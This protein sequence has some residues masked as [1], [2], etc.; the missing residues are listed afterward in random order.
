MQQA[1]RVSDFTAFVYLGRL[2]EYG[3]TERL[4]LNPPKKT[5]RGLHYRPVRLGHGGIGEDMDKPQRHFEGKLDELRRD[6][7]P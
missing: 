6:A 4:F 5:D 2:I 3:E 7:A 1:S